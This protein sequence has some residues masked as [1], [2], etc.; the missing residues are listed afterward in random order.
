M[1]RG[2]GGGQKSRK[3]WW[4][5]MWKPPNIYNF[6]QDKKRCMYVPTLIKVPILPIHWLHGISIQIFKYLF[7]LFIIFQFESIVGGGINSCVRLVFNH[8]KMT[9]WTV[10]MKNYFCFTFLITFLL[11]WVTPPTYILIFIT[12]SLWEFE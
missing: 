1:T 12:A 6:A 9:N 11:I 7:K 4:R 10:L 2:E 8:I 5:N 3:I